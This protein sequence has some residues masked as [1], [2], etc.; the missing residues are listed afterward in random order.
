MK[1]EREGV[2]VREPSGPV[3]IEVRVCEGR[4]PPFVV[5]RGTTPTGISRLEWVHNCTNKSSILAT[6]C[7][8]THGKKSILLWKVAI[9]TRSVLCRSPTHTSL[10]F[11]S[12]KILFMNSLYLSLSLSLSLPPPPLIFQATSF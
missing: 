1:L 3:V 10:F 2:R 5:A 4:S 8:P 7:N 6:A 12:R 9:F 11:F